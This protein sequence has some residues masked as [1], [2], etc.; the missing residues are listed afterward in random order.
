[1]G[2]LA[3]GFGNIGFDPIMIISAERNSYFLLTLDEVSEY[4]RSVHENALLMRF[5][6]NADYC[7]SKSF[8]YN[9]KLKSF[10]R[11]DAAMQLH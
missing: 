5:L 6:T 2:H 7:D 10:V 4:Y 1:M 9:K 8:I 11:R 3:L